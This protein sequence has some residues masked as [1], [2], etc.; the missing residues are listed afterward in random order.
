MN[1]S[2]VTLE[3]Y[4]SESTAILTGI[5]TIE[6]TTMTIVFDDDEVSY[7]VIG[8]TE[9]GHVYYGQDINNS[10]KAGWAK[11]SDVVYVGRWIENNDRFLFSIAFSNS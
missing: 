7:K 9:N 5:A 6:D 2:K 4:S 10:V 8:I 3:F 1:K 11:L